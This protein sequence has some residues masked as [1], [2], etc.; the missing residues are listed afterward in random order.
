[1]EIDCGAEAAAVLVAGCWLSQLRPRPTCEVVVVPVAAKGLATVVSCDVVAA[2][3]GSLTVMVCGAADAVD[4]LATRP[5]A[6]PLPLTDSVGS[7][8]ES[9]GVVTEDLG[10]VGVVGVV[11][12]VVGVAGVVGVVGIAGV[13]D[14]GGVVGEVEIGGGL[15]TWAWSGW[16]ELLRSVVWLAQ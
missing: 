9:A 15:A 11:V 14:L 13:V 16:L 3:R 12:D 1:M 2:D 5:T 4:T 10:L 6:P 8:T 7:A